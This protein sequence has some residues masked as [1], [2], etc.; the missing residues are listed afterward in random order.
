MNRLKFLTRTKF[1]WAAFVVSL[2]MLAAF[3]AVMRVWNFEML[4]MMDTAKDVSAALDSMT[5][6]QRRAHII[7]TLSLDV[8][9]PLTTAALLGGLV[10]KF[11]GRGSLWL[12]LPALGFLAADLIEGV[13][14]IMLLS[15][16][17]DFMDLKLIMTPLKM[18]LLTIAFI[19][20][21][22]ACLFGV[23]QKLRRAP[24]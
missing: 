4:D 8:A 7:M 6:E 14:Q 1:L 19:F 11:F 22:A 13:A 2:I 23:F 17:T 10:L 20:A 21:L 12:A 16:Q 24:I 3:G 9:Y 5:L 18:Q 15:G